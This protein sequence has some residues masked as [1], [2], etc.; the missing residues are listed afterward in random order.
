MNAVRGKAEAL[1]RK[2]QH[3]AALALADWT[4]RA[5]GPALKPIFFRAQ[6]Y[7]QHGDNDKALSILKEATSI[8]LL[9][10]IG[11]TEMFHIFI[12]TVPGDIKRGAIG[13]VV[14]GYV[15]KVVDDQGQEV[16]R[17]CIG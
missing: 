6:E 5:C 4:A 8:D 16:S 15:A 3:E 17:G 14:P 1:K 12:S 13:K 11:A 2:G 7:A 9:D 10:G